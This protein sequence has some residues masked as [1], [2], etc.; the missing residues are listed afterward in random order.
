M[1]ASVDF[2]EKKT[3]VVLI[4]GL[5]ITVDCPTSSLTAKYA[6]RNQSNEITPPNG[7]KLQWFFSM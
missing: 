1:S 4:T 6:L 7:K 5:T 2:I 3:Q